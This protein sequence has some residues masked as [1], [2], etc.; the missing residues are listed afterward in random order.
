MDLDVGT[1][2]PAGFIPLSARSDT[3]DAYGVYLLCEGPLGITLHYM[4]PPAPGTKWFEFVSRS[5]AILTGVRSS[6]IALG[7]MNCVENARLRKASFRSP[8]SA[9]QMVCKVDTI[10]SRAEIHLGRR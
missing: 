7:A 9:F 6:A 2:T 3:D 4:S 1:R 8:G 5:G 10:D